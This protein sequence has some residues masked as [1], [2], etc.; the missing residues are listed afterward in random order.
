MIL[1]TDKDK[2]LLNEVQVLK[3]NKRV[4]QRRDKRGLID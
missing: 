3:E 2:A 4:V 1:T